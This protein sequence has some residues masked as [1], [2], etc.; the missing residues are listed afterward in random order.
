MT[1]LLFYDAETT[2]LSDRDTILE[3]AWVICNQDGSER[4]SF[5]HRYTKISRTDPIIPL[6]RADNEDILW[7]ASPTMKPGLPGNETA[8]RMAVESGLFDDWLACP[9]TEILHSGTELQRLILDDI[10]VNCEPHEPVHLAGSGVA[11]FDQELLRDHC[12]RLI[13]PRDHFNGPVHYRTSDVSVAQMTLLGQSSTAVG[14]KLRNWYLTRAG[15]DAGT[16]V[17]SPE[18]K[19]WNAYGRGD[20]W[21]TW[22]VDGAAKHRALPDV[23]RG[24]VLQRALWEYGASLRQELGL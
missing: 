22:I 9:N 24:V 18:Q 2:G 16:V 17:A 19:P 11:Q 8:L 6:G 21:R 5:R 12:P 1:A 15:E 14:Q 20:Q 4:H 7:S 10:N 3:C 13:I 23:A